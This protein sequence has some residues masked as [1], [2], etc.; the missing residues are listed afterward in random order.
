MKGY[1]IVV[2]GRVQGVGYRHFI[3]CHAQSLSL[4]GYVKNLPDGRVEIF[5]ICEPDVLIS[6]VAFAKAGPPF[7]KVYDIDVQDID[8][9]DKEY[10]DFSVHF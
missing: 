4:C 10:D 7:S 1:K 8:C 5:V 9:F 6:F 3:F 2:S